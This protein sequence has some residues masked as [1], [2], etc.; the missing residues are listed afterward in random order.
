MN[1]EG[2]KALGMTGILHT[3]YD[4]TRRA[5]ETLFGVDLT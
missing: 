4:E 1:V 5:L 2:A 3:S